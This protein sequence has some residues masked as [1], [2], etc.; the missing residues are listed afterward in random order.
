MN[1]PHPTPNLHYTRVLGNNIPT[2][3]SGTPDAYDRLNQEENSAIYATP[4]EFVSN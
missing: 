4:V 2:N 3:F 1:E